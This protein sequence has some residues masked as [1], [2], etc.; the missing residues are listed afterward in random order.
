MERI[1]VSVIVPIYNTR[2]FLE[3]C[4]RSILNQTVSN[5]VLIV[6]DDGSTDDTSAVLE[7]LRA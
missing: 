1:A 6:V 5:L 4:V 2:P 7:K 3:E